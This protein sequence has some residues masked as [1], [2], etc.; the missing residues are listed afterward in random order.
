MLIMVT[1]R[2]FKAF[3]EWKKNQLE[4]PNV[5]QTQGIIKK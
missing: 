4:N 3:Q 1:L 5:Q 2:H